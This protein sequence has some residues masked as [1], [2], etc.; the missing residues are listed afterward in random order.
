MHGSS[1]NSPSSLLDMLRMQDSPLLPTPSPPPSLSLFPRQTSAP[2]EEILSNPYQIFVSPDMFMSPCFSPLPKNIGSHVISN[3][4][5]QTAFGLPAGNTAPPDMT[6][7]LLAGAF[8][9]GVLDQVLAQLTP[10]QLA[11]LSHQPP[12]QLL[13]SYQMRQTAYSPQYQQQGLEHLTTSMFT[14]PEQNNNDTR[15]SSPPQWNP[16]NM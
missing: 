15:Q 1:R 7:P 12:R 11:L 9:A 8:Q 4:G 10:H 14:V 6:H 16:F 2:Y 3:L 5:S 13:P